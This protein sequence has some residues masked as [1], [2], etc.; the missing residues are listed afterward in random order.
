MEHLDSLGFLIVTL[1]C[2]VTIVGKIWLIFMMLLRMAVIVLAGSP[3]Y[4][5]EQDRFVC[6]TLQP[7]CTNVCYDVF[8]PVSHLRFWLLQSVSALLPSAVFLVYVLHQGA[9]LAA[10]L[11]G[12]GPSHLPCPRPRGACGHPAVPDFTWGYIAHL[13]LRTLLEAAFGAL[14]Y[15]LFGFVVP[16]RFS[17]T[18]P[19]CSSVVDCYVS[20]PT[21]KSI[22]MLFVWA[23]SAL[24][25]LLSVADLVCSLRRRLS[26]S[27]GAHSTPRGLP[28]AT[29]ALGQDGGWEA[30]G[31]PAHPSSWRGTQGA[32]SPSGQ[33]AVSGQMELPEEL[34]SEAMSL[35]SDKLAERCRDGEGGPGGAEAVHHVRPASAPRSRL[36]QNSPSARPGSSRSA[37]H[38]RTRKS[39]WV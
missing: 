8:S 21:E 34:E 4:H 20:R 24:S 19:P 26:R 25:L 2:N 9:A 10:G 1:N 37:P 28:A 31:P 23:V 38:L 16:K 29:K 30:A 36:A 27:R 22:L 3:V 6:N 7:G 15:L 33:S 32:D 17:C 13:L 39:E 5:D 14:H 35:G 18:H 12:H 11:G